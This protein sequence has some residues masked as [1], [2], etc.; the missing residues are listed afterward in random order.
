MDKT[1]SALKTPYAPVAP[2]S[3]PTVESF[4]TPGVRTI[5]T[6]TKAPW[7]VPARQQ[8]K[9]LLYQV[10]SR[11]TL[12]LNGADRLD[13]AKLAEAL[14]T[15]EFRPAELEKIR[16]PLGTVPGRLGGVG[17]DDLEIIADRLLQNGHNL[18]TGAKENDQ[19][20]CN[21][22]IAHDIKVTRWEDLLTVTAGEPCPVTGA[23]LQNASVHRGGPY[24]QTGNP[25]YS[26]SFNA[27]IL[28]DRGQ[29]QPAIIGCYGTSVTLTVQAIIEQNHDE[30][31]IHWP[32][33][34]APFTVC[35]TIQ[36]ASPQS[37]ALELAETLYRQLS[38]R[39]I[40]TILDDRDEHPGV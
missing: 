15:A 16:Q 24:I 8:I 25:K 26:E 29:Q 17:V 28:N 4:A 32:V 21:V 6:L 22:C 37:P 36:D 5:E 1:V 34:V 11:P 33:T 3:L 20:L 7:N 35:L 39:G 31:G 40:E 9:S 18:T 30:Q 2:A 14:G 19:Q 38:D 12:L 23:P 13:E 10:A 27:L